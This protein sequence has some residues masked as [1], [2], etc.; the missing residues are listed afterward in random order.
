[1]LAE[2]IFSLDQSNFF[3]Y[4][5]FDKELSETV[6]IK[7]LSDQAISV[8][9]SW[10]PY[11]ASLQHTI[12]FA[13]LQ[14]STV[15]LQPF[16]VG[17]A[18]LRFA[19]PENL[20]P[21]DYYGSLLATT[22]GVVKKADF[23]LRFLGELTENVTLKSVAYADTSL[24]LSLENQGNITT[25]V[26]GKVVVTDFFGRIAAENSFPQ[27]ELKAE[28]KIDKTIDLPTILPGPYQAKVELV[29]GQKDFNQSRVYSFWAEL[30]FFS[31][32]TIF[33][34]VVLVGAA[35]LAWWRFHG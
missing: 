16:G 33:L 7:N 19:S 2:E 12:D 32:G 35:G 34:I 26:K 21:G 22:K 4:T 28:E 24:T 8:F 27:T 20:K 30:E 23:T 9:L 1:M 5:S 3:L 10:A 31:L 17:T 6:V 18:E 11:E 25:S 15:E 14:N 13:Q 29:S